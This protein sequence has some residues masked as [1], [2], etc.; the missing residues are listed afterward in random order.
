MF[1]A[2]SELFNLIFFFPLLLPDHT[3][4]CAVYEGETSSVSFMK[5]VFF[6]LR[7]PTAPAQNT[8]NTHPSYTLQP[9]MPILQ[10]SIKATLKQHDVTQ[11]S[12]LVTGNTEMARGK[13]KQ[14][15]I[16]TL[17]SL[18]MCHCVDNP[19]AADKCIIF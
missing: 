17:N 18:T 2:V 16:A 7:G 4:H 11:L 12:V 10:L 19:W 14:T 8:P 9:I 3:I 5:S 6:K 15:S 13:T 1:C